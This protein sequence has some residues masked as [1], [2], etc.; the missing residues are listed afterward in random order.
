[1]PVH[2]IRPCWG[3]WKS[4][5]HNSH[6]NVCYLSDSDTVLRFMSIQPVLFV[7]LD[8]YLLNLEY[9]DTACTDRNVQW[10]EKELTCSGKK[11]RDG[12]GEVKLK[13]Q[14]LDN[15]RCTQSFDS[16]PLTE[17]ETAD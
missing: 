5:G 17:R 1:M 14:K 4:R 6:L 15:A 13:G 11:G 10:K 7:V 2:V 8:L 16:L 3:Q 9:I 12:G